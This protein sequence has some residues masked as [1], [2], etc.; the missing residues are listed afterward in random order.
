MGA[1]D[2]QVGPMAADPPSYHWASKQRSCHMRLP[3]TFQCLARPHLGA[4]RALCLPAGPPARSV[5]PD[6]LRGQ[7]G[8][9]AGATPCADAGLLFPHA[10][11]PPPSYHPPSSLGA[12]RPAID[13]ALLGL[14]EAFPAHPLFPRIVD[15]PMREM[16]AVFGLRAAEFFHL[17]FGG[18]SDFQQQVWLSGAAHV[19]GML[20]SVIPPH[21]FPSLR[22]SELIGHRPRGKLLCSRI[23]QVFAQEIVRGPGA[24]KRPV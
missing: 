1:G 14:L 6:G 7:G 11:P 8:P 17:V 20:F 5:T 12:L 23:C 13:W 16:Y 18:D 24:R 9:A 10:A 4:E 2:T 15:M 22:C 21:L 3:P 19:A